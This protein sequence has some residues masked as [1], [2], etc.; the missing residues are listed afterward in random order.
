MSDQTNEQ[1]ATAKVENP[2]DTP[3]QSTNPTKR[4]LWQW[5]LWNIRQKNIAAQSNNGQRVPLD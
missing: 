5:A 4:R 1:Q 3:L 2:A